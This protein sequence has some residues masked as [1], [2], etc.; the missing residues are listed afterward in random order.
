MFVFVRDDLG[1]WVEEAY[2]KSPSPDPDDWFGDVLALSSDGQTLVVGTWRESSNAVGVDGDP[3]DNSAQYAGAAYVYARDEQGEWAE[4]AYLKGSNT[5]NFDRFASS[6]AIS[7]E[8]NLVVVGAPGEDSLATGFDGAQDNGFDV[9]RVGAVYMFERAEDLSWSELHYIKASDASPF[10]GFGMSVALSSEGNTLAV[11]AS[12]LAQTVYVFQ[13]P[14]GPGSE[15]VEEAKVV[16]A[17]TEHGDRFGERVALSADGDTLAV[18]ASEERSAAT[19]V[20][21]DSA[22]N[23]ALEAGAAYVFR[24]AMGSWTEQAYIKAS[25]TEA[26]DRFGQAIGLSGDGNLLVVGAP[27]EN[28]EGVG[29]ASDDLAADA[30]QFQAGAAYVFAFAGPGWAQVRYVKPTN[31]DERDEFG[32]GLALSGDG[33]TL[34]IGAYREDDTSLGING[35]PLD[36]LAFESGAVFVY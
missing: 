22:D 14:D 9:N 1:E 20:D 21:G 6:V 26:F 17:S 13:R 19:G 5:E 24:R 32:Y 35:E 11:G 36:T 28:G 16:S 12:G 31:T 10:D 7:G 18:V 33:Q 27:H 25:N 30:P 4:Q 29:L 2:I 15:W 34:A 3:S 23:S 8:G